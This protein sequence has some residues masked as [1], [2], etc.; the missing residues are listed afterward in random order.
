[1]A[2]AAGIAV[3]LVGTSFHSQSRNDAAKLIGAIKYAYNESVTKN[4]YYRIVFDFEKQSYW[5][6]YS[7]ASFFVEKETDEVKKAREEKEKK[8]AL[9]KDSFDIG[10]EE[11]DVEE[12]ANFTELEEEDAAVRLTKLDAEVLLKDVYVDHQEVPIN[13]GQAYLYFFPR[14]LT[15]LAVI[16]FTDETEESFL[17]LV[18]NPITGRCTVKREYV[19]YDKLNEE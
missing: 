19:E 15:E 17:S 11:E 2:I 10:E 7:D 13:Q 4:L 9:E 1:M 12:V 5:L 3:G 16:N 8:K 6:E 14:G 18:V